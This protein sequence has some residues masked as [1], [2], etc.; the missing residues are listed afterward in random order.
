MA[1]L[2]ARWISL[3]E[4]EAQRFVFFVVYL[5]YLPNVNDQHPLMSNYDL[6]N[7]GLLPILPEVQQTQLA[8]QVTRVTTAAGKL[9]YLIQ[10]DDA[11]D[12]DSDTSSEASEAA[13]VT[14]LDEIAEDLRTDTQCLM[15]LGSRFN[16]QAVGPTII[17][18][19][20]VDPTK[21]SIWDPS[22]N[23]IDRIRWRFPRCDEALTERLGKANWARVL[24]Y[25]EVKAQNIRPLETNIST[26]KQSVAAIAMKPASSKVASTTFHESGLGTSIAEPSQYAETIVSY[27][28]GNGESV[29]V[30]SLPEGA[31]KGIPF[32]CVACCNRIVI[33]NKSAWKY[34]YHVHP[35]RVARS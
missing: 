33:T 6:T 20:A 19:V 3:E 30:P 24:R 15:D 29:R 23:F 16:E 28:G 14:E 21:L 11:Y 5:E 32:N 4:L 18:E 2:T 27:R 26:S 10:Q 17:T 22:T 12:S 1:S 8:S 34:A 13:G 25:Q 7:T 31:K 9:K 35:C